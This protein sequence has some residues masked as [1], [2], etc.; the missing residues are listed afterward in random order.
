MVYSLVKEAYCMMVK[1]VTGKETIKEGKGKTKKKRKK[2]RK[3]FY[4]KWGVRSGS[5]MGF[6]GYVTK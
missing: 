5:E 4:K 6:D 3:L 2:K 1:E